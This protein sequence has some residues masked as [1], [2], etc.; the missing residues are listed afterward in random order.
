M[1]SSQQL[2]IRLGQLHLQLLSL[3]RDLIRG[4]LRLGE[5]LFL[6]QFDRPGQRLLGPRQFLFRQGDSLVHLVD[7]FGILAQLVLPEVLAGELHRQLGLI[8]VAVGLAGDDG[9]VL[10]GVDVRRL[11]VL[12]PDL[13][14]DL[15]VLERPGIQLDQQL[16][17]ADPRALGDQRDD[18]GPALDLVLDDDLV[19]G[20]DRAGLDDADG[21]RAAPGREHGH[22]LSRLVAAPD[23]GEPDDAYA[24]R[25]HEGQ[26]AEESGDESSGSA[27]VCPPIA[28]EPCQSPVM[29]GLITQGGF[30]THAFRRRGM[31]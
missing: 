19:A 18:G 28:S 1:K 27:A 31:P 16:S 2:E 8:D 14:V 5:V 6:Q 22:V 15:A 24:D 3:D 17:L 23:H 13:L 11:G 9:Q 10:L 30:S 4:L 12:H 7:V 25:Q 21:Q 26:A 29:T 20:L